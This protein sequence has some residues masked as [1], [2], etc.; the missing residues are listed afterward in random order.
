MNE[1]FLHYVWKFQKLT[2]L[3]LSTVAGNS[4]QVLN[5]GQHNHN[6]GP[7]FFNGQI[8]I[9]NQKWAGTVEIHIKSSDWY[10]HGHEKDP[11]YDSVILH[12]VWEHNVDVFREDNT[13]IPTL[14]LKNSIAPQILK[15]YQKLFHTKSY[16]INCENSFAEVSALTVTNCIE[17]LYI[18]RL[19]N[20]YAL[21]QERLNKL[22]NHWEAVLFE[23]L[24]KNFGLNVNGASFLSIA[25]SIPFS[26][27]QKCRQSPQ[28]LEALLM[29]QAGFFER[30]T[31]DA[32]HKDQK[33]NYIFLASKFSLSSITVAA[34]KYFRLRP[35]NFPTI[36]LSQLSALYHERPSLFSEVIKIDTVAGFYKLFE[37]SALGYWD[38]HYNFGVVAA[39]RK[40][41]LTKKFIDLL[42]INT[43]IP[44]KF[45]YATSRGKNVTEALIALASKLPKEKNSIVDGFNRLKPIVENAFDSQGVLQLKNEYCD[46]LKCMQ[47]A[48]GNA[49]LRK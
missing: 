9:N 24:C 4:L 19:E 8:I 38:T 17:R 39:P 14:E 6:A 10:A 15:N 42:I 18:E 2:S 22:N 41:K 45:A 44:L 28:I 20:K 29:G 12:V 48:V 30:E 21:I 34:P 43:V 37:V 46:K 31:Q 32:Y 47:C 49:L 23:M 26:V 3:E 1:D 13:A 33:E 35:P 11:A 16:W 36:R 7:D 25:Q 27:L 5:V 40:R